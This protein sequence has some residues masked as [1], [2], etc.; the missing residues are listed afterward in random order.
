MESRQDAFSGRE[1]SLSLACQASPALT[2]MVSPLNSPALPRLRVIPR[3]TRA[4]EPWPLCM[5]QLLATGTVAAAYECLPHPA[6]SCSNLPSRTRQTRRLK[7]AGSA[8]LLPAGKT[9]GAGAAGP[10]V[11]EAWLILPGAHLTRGLSSWKTEFRSRR[12]QAPGTPLGRQ[13]HCC[14]PR[15]PKFTR[16]SPP[17]EPQKVLPLVTGSLL[18]LRQNEVVRVVS[19]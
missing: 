9:A 12:P 18:R 8:D 5:S 10:R 11:L 13:A 7:S 1:G 15:P 17:P 14:L 16:E 19:L 2:S 3:S 4:L 6:S